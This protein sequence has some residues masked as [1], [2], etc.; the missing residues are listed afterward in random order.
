MREALNDGLG[1]EGRTIL[2]G[3]ASFSLIHRQ[4]SPEERAFLESRG[5]LSTIATMRAMARTEG[6][7]ALIE[8]KAVA[9]SWP[10][11]GQ[12]R[13]AP[14]M[15]TAEALGEKDGAYGAAVEEALLGAPRPEGGRPVPDRTG[16]LR[17]PHGA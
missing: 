8:I 4:L 5:T 13:F 11:L 3:D 6:D 2:G 7:A 15:T 12:A 10:S 16:D 1:R 9:P 17:R 14:P